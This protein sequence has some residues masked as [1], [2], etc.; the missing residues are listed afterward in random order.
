ML[1]ILFGC[2]EFALISCFFIYNIHPN[3]IYINLQVL[4]FA[5]DHAPPSCKKC[6]RTIPAETP[7][8]A[9]KVSLVHV[10]QYINLLVRP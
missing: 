6:S 3:I 10:P 1:C 7:T 5:A 9:E 4:H 8:P 2:N